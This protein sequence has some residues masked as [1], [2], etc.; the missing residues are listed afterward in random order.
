MDLQTKLQRRRSVVDTQGTSFESNPLKSIADEGAA[1]DLPGKGIT[2]AL[3]DQ[4]QHK[5]K[6]LVLLAAA[7]DTST[8]AM[9]T[10]AQAP[11]QVSSGMVTPRKSVDVGSAVVSSPGRRL[12]GAS[13]RLSGALLTSPARRMSGASSAALAS[14]MRSSPA[15]RM[16]DASGAPEVA[17]FDKLHKR[18]ALV[19]SHG[20]SFESSPTVRVADEGTAPQDA[21]ATD[22]SWKN[23]DGCRKSVGGT[24]S[25]RASPAT[26]R[27]SV[28]KRIPC[29]S[30]GQ[31]EFQQIISF[32]K[33]LTDKNATTFESAPSIL[34]ENGLPPSP[35]RARRN[36]FLQV[37][38][39]P[40][41]PPTTM[42]ET[43]SG[44]QAD[45]AGAGTIH[46]KRVGRRHQLL[47]ELEVEVAS[48]PAL[49]AS[50][51]VLRDSVLPAPQDISAVTVQNSQVVWWATP[52]TSKK[53][54]RITSSTFTLNASYE[55]AQF[56]LSRQKTP[57][58]NKRNAQHA[59]DR[60][61][62]S[63]R[64]WQR[65]ESRVLVALFVGT[66]GKPPR[67]WEGPVME[68]DFSFNWSGERPLLCGFVYRM[69]EK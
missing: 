19:E 35:T 34:T 30:P 26:K 67:E 54:I 16:S 56:Q 31:T 12:S 51:S 40:P 53:T 41:P 61:T 8:S 5:A 59:T 33:G 60:W 57:W 62:L 52:D 1:V 9:D 65:R 48:A 37:P 21:P 36:S 3:S 38:S 45:E 25:P 58:K 4:T 10:D 64:G 47:S 24:G 14:P 27:Q 39:L 50:C 44:H 46:T 55:E 7:P 6:E 42:T 69:L 15:R 20:A 32:R 18:R 22:E 23:S 28:T 11:D 49:L 66:E 29:A 17:L 63:L 2:D 43:A 13:R 68:E